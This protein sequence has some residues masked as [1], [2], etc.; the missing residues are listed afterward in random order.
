MK[1]EIDK[2]QFSHIENLK[3]YSFTVVISNRYL[4]DYPFTI[5]FYYHRQLYDISVPQFV[6]FFV[7][8]Y[9]WKDEITWT[10]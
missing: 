8:I 7:P 9:C 6:P 2:D 10:F 1:I 5:S 4:S 3:A